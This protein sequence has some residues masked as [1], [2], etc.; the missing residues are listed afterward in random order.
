MRHN[1]KSYVGVAT[2]LGLARIIERIRRAIQHQ[3]WFQPA[4]D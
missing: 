2:R 3:T 4:V 1:H